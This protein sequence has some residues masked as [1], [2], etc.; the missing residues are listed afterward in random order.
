MKVPCRSKKGKSFIAYLVLLLMMLSL[1]VYANSANV[2]LN[3]RNGSVRS[4]M[5]EVEKQT[6]YT[7]V[8]RNNVVDPNTKVS[9]VCKNQSLQK[10]LEQ[11]FSPI[12]V[13]YSFVNGTI[14]LVKK[15]NKIKTAEPTRAAYVQQSPQSDEPKR[16]VKGVVTDSH[17]EPIIGASVKLKGGSVGA[18]TNIDGEFDIE[19]DNNATL[20]VTY[21]GFAPSEVLVQGDSDLKVVMQE[22]SAQKLNEVV[23]VGYGTQKKVT[24]TGAVSSMS[25][26]ELKKTPQANVSNSLVG[27]LPGVIAVQRSGQPG[28]SQSTIRIRGVGTFN[29]SA[30]PLVMVDGIED[31]NY[32]NIDPSEIENISILKDAS[33][34]AVY[35]VRGANGVILITT[36][37]G[38]ESK[39][40]IRLTTSLAINTFTN[41]RETVSSYDFARGYNDARKYDSYLS[42]GYTPYYTDE[43]IEKFRTGEDP[44]FYPS[45]NWYDTMYRKSTTQ[46]QH[47]LNISGGTKRVKY[48]VSVGYFNENGMFNKNITDFIKDYNAQPRFSRYNFRGNLDFDVTKNLFIGIDISSQ[49]EERM[50]NTSNINRLIEVVTKANPTI[51]PGIVDDKLI[52]LGIQGSGGQTPH[53]LM[54]IDGYTRDSRTYLNGTVNVRYKLDFITKGLLA[55]AKVSYMNFSRDTRA[56]SKNPLIYEPYR[57]TDGSIVYVPQNEEKPYTTSSTI[58]KN[59]REYVEY[60]LEYNRTFGDHTFGGLLLYNQNK[61]HDPTLLYMVP[62]GYQGVVGRVTYDYQ[63]KYLLEYDFGYNGTE[64]FAEGKRFGYFP[65]YSVGWV[66]TS[67][68]FF[69]QNK[70]VNFIKLRASYGEVG[71]DQVGGERFLYRPSSYSYTS[72]YYYWGETGQ[73]WTGY[74]GSIE[75]KAGNPDLT[76]ERAKK[77]NAGIDMHMFDSKLRLTAEWFSEKRDNILANLGTVPAFVGSDL[78]AY[79][80][81]KMKNSGYELEAS[82]SD[83]VGKFNYWVKANY[84]FAHNK[85]EFQDEPVRAYPYLQGTGQRA[86]QY[87]GLIAEGFYNT[88][89]EVNDPYRPK[90]S[91]N[92]NKLQP[93]DIKYRDVNG[94]GVIDPYDFVPIG[95]S[96]FPEKVFAFSFGGSYKGFDFSVMFQGSSNVSVNYS[97]H[98]RYGYREGATVPDYILEKSWTQDRYEQ[99]ATIEFPHLSEGDV[100][101]SHNYAP[102]STMWIRDASYLRLKNVDVGYT[103]GNRLFSKVGVSSVR[104][105]VNGNNLLTWSDMLPGIDPESNVAGTN[106]EPYPLVRTINFGM[107]INF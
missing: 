51:S 77:F 82:Y 52:T 15:E 22:E 33:S 59:R 9:V 78:P 43:E 67:E 32:N 48:F 14:V 85:I 65:A 21:I 24:V 66:P 64:N 56:F 40:K 3:I 104:V 44:I 12:Q 74:R 95:Y 73:N 93:G 63:N 97:R 13:D 57:T 17:G 72:N 39:P 35:G 45:T 2:T 103:F 100:V 27:R 80:L 102:N 31:A 87:F 99:G 68:K 89:E 50:G 19:A 106:S 53:T 10:T 47:N 55:K 86:G 96:N 94:D 101:Q 38:V 28:E 69:P 42:G 1:S 37:R 90:S 5:R 92:N 18:V 29:G 84:T 49:N 30:D 46:S 76:W 7:F 34:T 91:Y 75:G 62:R 98:A 41:I 25:E 107:N 88:W 60:G 54:L 6:N 81:G 11:V 8:Y 26:A 4:F 83:H 20:I 70:I 79:N 36:K 23:V 16:K 61:L 58:R 105:Y 71:N